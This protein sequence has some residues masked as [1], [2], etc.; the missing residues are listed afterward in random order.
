MRYIELKVIENKNNPSDPLIYADH[1]FN[2][3]RQRGRDENLDWDE[4]NKLQSLV[5]KID[6]AREAG[7]KWLELENAEW[8][9]AARK[10]KKFSWPFMLDSIFE[11]VS[12]VAN[13]PEKDPR[14]VKAEPAE[15]EKPAKLK[16]VASEKA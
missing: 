11:F 3:V 12:D 6:D 15:K 5:K 2:I 1:L 13:A 8:E 14:E 4:M 16:A 10:V 9:Q 7:D